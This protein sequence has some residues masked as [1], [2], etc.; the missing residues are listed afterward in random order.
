MEK[1][2]GWQYVGPSMNKI[3]ELAARRQ[4]LEDRRQNTEVRTNKETLKAISVL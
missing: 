1:P 4:K 2:K 3:N